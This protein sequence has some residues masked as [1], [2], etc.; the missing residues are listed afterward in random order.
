MADDNI[1]DE[2]IHGADLQKNLDEV[3]NN[4]KRA[5]ADFE[6][7]K[8]RQEQE[9]AELVDFVRTDT[10]K[11]LLPVIDSLEQALRHMPEQGD[12]SIS[13]S[14]NKFTQDYK[15]WQVGMQGIVIQLE[16]SLAELGVKKIEAVGK[17]FDPHFHEAV[18]EV[19]G[20]EDGIVVDQFQTGFEV[21]GKLIR[22]SQV[23]ISKRKVV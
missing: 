21:N 7:Y 19:E 6:N 23:I 20:E 11:R 10:F 8:R 5:L 16:Q 2:P 14:D 15:N 3:T 18:K 9:G 1:Q 22:P 13:E 17:K 4:W 12:Q